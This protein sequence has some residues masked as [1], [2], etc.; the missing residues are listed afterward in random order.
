[1]CLRD[2]VL[3]NEAVSCASYHLIS[4]WSA[5]VYCS[6]VYD[7]S[8]VFIQPCGNLRVCLS[9]ACLC[10]FKVFTFEMEVVFFKETLILAIHVSRLLT[11]VNSTQ[12]QSNNIFSCTWQHWSC[13]YFIIPCFFDEAIDVVVFI[14]VNL[15][16]LLSLFNMNYFKTCN[17]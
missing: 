12:R 1:M 14:V 11:K 10:P 5:Q 9:L 3:L 6:N 16:S 4:L 17:L 7:E 13:F 2:T 8:Y 15:S